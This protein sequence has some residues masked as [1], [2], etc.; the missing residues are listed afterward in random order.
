MK[1]IQNKKT[2]TNDWFTE[3]ETSLDR[4]YDTLFEFYH[5]ILTI[6][7]EKGIKKSDLAKKMNKSRSYITQLLN[8]NLNISILKM[9]ELSDAV[10]YDIDKRIIN[11]MKE[12]EFKTAD[13]IR[14]DLKV[15][16]PKSE[17]WEINDTG[18]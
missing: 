7:D 17:K 16:Q 2:S 1:N 8:N 12:K 15:D 4:A 18:K 14:V 11:S 5:R 9:V 13:T 6:M 3:E 10:G